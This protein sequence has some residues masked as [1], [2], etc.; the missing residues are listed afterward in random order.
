MPVSV[1]LFV[2]G[3][4]VHKQ[5]IST[6]IID[7][8][9]IPVTIPRITSKFECLPLSEVLDDVAAGT[10]LSGVSTV[11]AAKVGAAAKIHYNT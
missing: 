1:G 2:F 9:S 4:S 5:S 11:D 6:H 8:M 7:M 10:C 3:L